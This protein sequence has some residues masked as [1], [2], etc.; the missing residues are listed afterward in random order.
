MSAFMILET[1]SWSSLHSAQR[2]TEGRVT[3]GLGLLVNQREHA[4]R[5]WV[6]SCRR[7][8]PTVATT[9]GTDEPV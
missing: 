4:L 2:Q 6:C 8:A 3:P 5:R 7:S 1:G 9:S